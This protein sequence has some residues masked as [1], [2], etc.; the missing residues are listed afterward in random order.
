MA[1][2]LDALERAP[3]QHR[4]KRLGDHDA[5]D[6][7]I[8]GARGR[9]ALARDR[10]AQARFDV[11]EVGEL[12]HRRDSLAFRHAK[13]QTRV[14]PLPMLI[15]VIL[16][17]AGCVVFLVQQVRDLRRQKREPRALGKGRA[18][19]G[20]RRLGLAPLG[21]AARR[22]ATVWSGRL[23]IGVISDTH[24]LL[25]PEAV[26]ALRGAEHIIHAGDVGAPEVLT[27]LAAIAPVTA[28]RGNNDRRRLGGADP[29]DGGARRRT[30]LCIYVLHDLN[31]LDL[32]P[33]AGGFSVVVA[34]HSHQPA[35]EP[36]RTASCSSTPGARGRGVSACPICVG[37]LHV[38]RT[39][40]RG[41]S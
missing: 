27:A 35:Q 29:G 28:V 6:R 4:R 13:V 14:M 40:P 10:G 22:V 11:D 9:D 32:D 1:A 18:A 36:A 37:R 17:S 30:A 21:R 16:V 31:E 23:L 7:R 34:G 20:R 12:G 26:A 8:A 24:G 33:S 3:H 38:D 25:R 39:A 5:Q 41:A 15:I 2:P 19:R